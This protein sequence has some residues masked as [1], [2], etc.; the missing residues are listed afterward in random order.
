MSAMIA[1]LLVLSALTGCAGETLVNIKNAPP[2]PPA[3]TLSVEVETYKET[4]RDEDGTVLAECAYE[5]PVMRALLE[6]GTSLKEAGSPEQEKAL[7][8]AEAFNA[9]F[10]QWKDNARSLADTAR[11]DRAVRS[12]ESLRFYPYDDNLGCTVYQTERLVSVS[13]VY[14]T[15]TGGAHPN[16]ILL[17]WNFDLETGE[18]FTPDTLD[19]DGALQ[20]Y[21]QRELCAKARQTV[22]EMGGVEP[23]GWYW[24]N[25]EDT[26]AEWSSYAVSFDEDGMTV[27]FSPYELANYAAG[28][29]IFR[30]SYEELR[31]RLNRHAKA[32][33]GLED[34]R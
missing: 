29:Q 12:G 19:E 22:R 13:G 32:L 21:V 11:E 15:W 23:D 5:L 20:A 16:T 1:L 25:Y 31:P 8:A 4:V 7:A 3:V 17:S 26:L 6:D 24:T 28:P 14:S 9:P 33:L 2:Q 34:G 18:F 27:G 10:E 30:F